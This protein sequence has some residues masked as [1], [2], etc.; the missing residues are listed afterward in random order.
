MQDKENWRNDLGEEYMKTSE[1]QSHLS[2]SLSLFLCHRGHL[3]KLIIDHGGFVFDWRENL[4]VLWESD[5]LCKLSPPHR[6][7]S[8]SSPFQPSRS[9]WVLTGRFALRQEHSGWIRFDFTFQLT[10]LSK[11]RTYLQLNPAAL[12]S[13]SNLSRHLATQPA[14]LHNNT[15]KSTSKLEQAVQAILHLTPPQVWYTT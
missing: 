3:W 9:N 13:L 12:R 11:K 15:V 10:R 1:P 2:R 7:L 6:A 14:T 4:I 5:N 8:K